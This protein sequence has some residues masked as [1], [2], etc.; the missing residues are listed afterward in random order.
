MTSS[1][2]ARS[3]TQQSAGLGLFHDPAEWEDM[4]GWHERVAELR[5][6]QGAVWVDAPDYQPYLALLRHADVYAVERNHETWKNTTRVTLAPDAFFE[7]VMGM[8]MPEPKSLVQLDDRDHRLHRQVA[9][10][11]FK[12]AA[13]RTL[14]G[15]HR[16]DRRGVRPADV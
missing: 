4:V 13:T 3:T 2:G 12:P 10:D 16:R 7:Q 11:W 6:Q 8:G 14:A 15:A 1:Q 5:R 9:N